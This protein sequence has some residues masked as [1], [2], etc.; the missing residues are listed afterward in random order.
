MGG[1]PKLVLLARYGAKGRLSGDLRKKSNV[2]GFDLP[3]G[4][5][6]P[7]MPFVYG[8]FARR[9]IRP[10]PILTNPAFV[11]MQRIAILNAG[12][13]STCP[14]PPIY[15]RYSRYRVSRVSNGR[16][17][18]T[19]FSTPALRHAANDCRK[20]AQTKEHRAHDS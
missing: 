15:P 10:P 6:T 14:V 17:W 1:I 8:S 3:A 16:R 5:D 12:L 9:P 2:S 4:R 18:S 7:A 20:H 13:V 11:L 19:A